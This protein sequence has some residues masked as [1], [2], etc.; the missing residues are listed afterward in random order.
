MKT[1]GHKRAVFSIFI[2]TALLFAQ[3][4]VQPARAAAA[5]CSIIYSGGN[6]WVIDMCATDPDV[7]T[8]MDVLVNGVSQGS[9]ALVRIINRNIRQARHKLQ[10][11]MPLDTCA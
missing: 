1:D 7:V 2:L 4:Y 10:S 8:P 11:S 5:N 3:F 9:A 6:G